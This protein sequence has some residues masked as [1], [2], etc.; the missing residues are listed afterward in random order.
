MRA[1]MRRWQLELSIA[2]IFAAV[3]AVGGFDCGGGGGGGD[4]G[5]PSGPAEVITA[6]TGSPVPSG[7][8]KVNDNWDP[9][10]CGSPST[11]TYNVSTYQ[12]YDNKPVGAVMS[13]CAGAIPSGWVLSNTYWSPTSCG[14]PSSVFDNMYSIKRV[15]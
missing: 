10:A 13:V 2:G 11:I 14:H 8:I 1:F 12:R 9:T 4:G 6:C 3:L 5:G 15:T 7:Y